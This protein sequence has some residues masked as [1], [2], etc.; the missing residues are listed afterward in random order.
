M[1]PPTAWVAVRKIS[2]E[3]LDAR[4]VTP[5]SEKDC[6]EKFFLGVFA[7]T[8]RTIEHPMRRDAYSSS[9]PSGPSP[10]GRR[11]KRFF[12][13]VSRFSICKYAVSSDESRHMRR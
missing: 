9:S 7:K 1:L 6:E 13:G 11:P 12:C 4:A 10:G 8:L 2:A 5:W 3:Q